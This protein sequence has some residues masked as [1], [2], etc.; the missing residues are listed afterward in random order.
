MLNCIYIQIAK[1]IVLKLRTP[2]TWTNDAQLTKGTYY[3]YH[4]TSIF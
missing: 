2:A 4:L 3:I 1:S